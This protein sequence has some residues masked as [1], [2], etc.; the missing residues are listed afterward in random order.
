MIYLKKIIFT[1]IL[2]AGFVSIGY[3]QLP[4]QNAYLL[5]SIDSYSSYSACWEYAAPD[6]R[7]HALLGAFEGTS[8]V[9]TTNS[10]N[11]HEVGFVPTSSTSS[12][13]SCNGWRGMKVYSHY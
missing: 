10:A 1:L 5:K 11:I 12:T 4:N 6:G 8:F 3:S 9:V 13:N 2:L 7:E